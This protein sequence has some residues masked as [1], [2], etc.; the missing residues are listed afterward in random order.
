MKSFYQHMKKEHS[1]EDSRGND[2]LKDM[3]MD[4]EFPKKETERWKI[5]RYLK[6]KRACEE[7]L[8]TF[9]EYWLEYASD[10]GINITALDCK[11]YVDDLVDMLADVRFDGDEAEAIFNAIDILGRISD[12]LDEA[13]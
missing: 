9:E 8:D 4:E 6:R 11:R 7:C 10:V 13:C 12:Y 2:L 3:D 5:L 1:H